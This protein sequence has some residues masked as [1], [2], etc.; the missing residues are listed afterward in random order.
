MKRT[1]K[2]FESIICNKDDD[3]MVCF[4]VRG[5]HEEK[6]ID[7]YLTLYFSRCATVTP[8]SKELVGFRLNNISAILRRIKEDDPNAWVCSKHG[9]IN[10]RTLFNRSLDVL[11]NIKKQPYVHVR[12]A[13][14]QH[15][16]EFAYVPFV[17]ETIYGRT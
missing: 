5:Q 6:C 16:V 1:A 10:V 13:S 3:S 7:S 15:G 11:P 8:N 14:V 2:K 4:F 9:Y 17:K 12:N